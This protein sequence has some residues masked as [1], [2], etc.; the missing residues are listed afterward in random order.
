MELSFIKK[1]KLRISA[2][3]LRQSNT[4]VRAGLE[5]KA[6]SSLPHAGPLLF[7]G[8]ALPM[9]ALNFFHVTNHVH[10]HPC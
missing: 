4:E 7:N 9:M 5:S 2:L 1:L 10:V 6:L 8:L 3:I